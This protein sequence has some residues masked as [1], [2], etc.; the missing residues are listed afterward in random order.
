M[1]LHASL[2]NTIRVPTQ[3]TR[4]WYHTYNT[5]RGGVHVVRT[6]SILVGDTLVLP[7]QMSS[8]RGTAVCYQDLTNPY[9][10]AAER[11]EG[12]GHGVCDE[13]WFRDSRTAGDSNLAFAGELDYISGISADETLF[14]WAKAARRTYLDSRGSRDTPE[15]GTGSTE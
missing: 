8:L 5:R 11:P 4:A 2:L 9:W 1:P 12:P 15:T 14:T 6:A 13:C 10:V 3:P 7:A